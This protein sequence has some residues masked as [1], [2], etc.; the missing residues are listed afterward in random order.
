[1]Q[2][3]AEHVSF[4]LPN[5]YSRVGYLL[6]AI[7]NNDP[8]LQATLANVEEDVGNGTAENQG[9]RNNFELAVA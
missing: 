2:A 9:K 6:D 5:E 8:P 4:Q 3:C 1:M 7:E